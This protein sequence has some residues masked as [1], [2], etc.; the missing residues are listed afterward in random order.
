MV[1]VG[2]GVVVLVVFSPIMVVVVVQVVVP[3]LLLFKSTRS[4]GARGGMLLRLSLKS[5]QTR[6]GGRRGNGGGDRDDVGH[7]P[8]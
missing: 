2:R 6:G 5:L 3:Q 4:V 8:H 1:C 7:R